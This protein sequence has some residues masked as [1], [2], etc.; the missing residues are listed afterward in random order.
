M[1]ICG[2]VRRTRVQCAILV[3]WFYVEDDRLEC[4]VS[5]QNGSVLGGAKPEVAV[6]I[7]CYNEEK[8]IRKVVEDFH[9]VLPDATIYVYDNN[10]SDRT[11]EEALA[12]WSETVVRHEYA[13]GK[14]NVIRRMFREI[15]AD[16]Y[17]MTD[18]DDTYP[19]DAA[20]QLVEKVLEHQADMV[21]G[22]RLSS[23]YFEENKR[24]FHNMGNSV[25]RGLVNSVFKCGYNDIMTGYRAF[26]YNFVKAFPI[27]SAGFE[28]ETEMSIFA[29]D[30]NMQVENVVIEYRDRP[31]GSESKLNTIPDGLKVLRTIMRLFRDYRPMRFFSL[32]ALV[33]AVLALAFFIPVFMS[34]LKTGIVMQFPT[35]IVCGFTFS[36]ALMSLFCGLVLETIRQKDRR[37]FEA[38]LQQIDVDHK[39]LARG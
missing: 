34:Y 6:L 15:D 20:P 32:L 21:V 18:G 16:C 12:G 14:G 7:P 2:D 30:R 28:I 10:S 3:R 37:D 13:Q 1:G 8:T 9:R 24:P 27:L 11:C 4:F 33:L 39:I 23:T 17:V 35:L 38:R 5:S 31:E 22:D 19:A 29:A 25:V 36:A 26:S